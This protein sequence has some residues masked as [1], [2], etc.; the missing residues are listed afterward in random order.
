MATL[1]GI[2]SKLST[3][4]DSTTIHTYIQHGYFFCMI[5]KYS[6]DW[7]DFIIMKLKEEVFTMEM[8]DD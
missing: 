8:V 3:Q 4:E 2:T 5:M 1:R 7:I 6:I